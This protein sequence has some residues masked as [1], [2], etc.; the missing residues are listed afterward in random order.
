LNNSSSIEIELDRPEFI[1]EIFGPQ[2]VNIKLIEKKFNT[3]INA[4]GTKVQ[5]HG[6]PKASERVAKLLQDLQGLIASG[7]TLKSDDVKYAVRLAWEEPEVNL[8][9]IF[10]ER[11]H[12]AP[13]KGF[14][15]AKG[16][17]Q[18]ELI[19]A[20]KEADIVMAIGPAG[21]G[22][23]Y[24]AV[25][26]AVEG[27]LKHKYK[28]IILVRP[29]VEAGEKLGFLPGDMIEKINPYIMPLYDA[30]N[31]M[32]EPGQVRGLIEEG[33]IEIAPLAYMRGRTLSDAF[34]ILDEAQNSTRQ[35]MKMFLTRLGFRAKMIVTGDITQ[36]DLPHQ[37]DSGLLHAK[38]LL[39]SVE[40]IRFVTFL[41]KDVVRH[42]LVKKIISAYEA[43]NL[44]N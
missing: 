20:V 39:S 43:E 35:Q 28:K 4:R 34:I 14:I 25:A 3:R 10:S 5:I 8:E 11:V 9:A 26:L 44:E 40:G 21:T 41:E 12:V 24:L 37:T 27:L 15:Y 16:S 29:A 1:P 18:K 30:L 32:M 7:A 17:T 31:D 22:K 6:D 23:T 36:I 42:E 38:R 19:R 13:A 2:D 33:V